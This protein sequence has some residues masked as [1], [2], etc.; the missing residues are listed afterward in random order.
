MMT[1]GEALTNLVFAKITSLK[2]SNQRCFIDISK[3]NCI[4]KGKEIN[5]VHILCV[6]HSQDVKCSGNWM[7]PG[8]RGV[9]G[10]ELF[11]T[12][13]AMCDIMRKLGIAVDGG[14]DSLSMSARVENE[15]VNA[16][17]ERTQEPGPS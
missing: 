10:A 8:K 4:E 14:K 17:G 1:V 15:L 13:T 2:V 6:D 12:C 16:P 5:K 7:W 11:D 9:E 3:Q